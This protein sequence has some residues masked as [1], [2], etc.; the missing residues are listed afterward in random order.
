MNNAGKYK[1]ESEK[2]MLFDT[3]SQ[4]LVT[5]LADIAPDISVFLYILY[6]F[7]TA[8]LCVGNFAH[9]SEAAVLHLYSMY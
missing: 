6:V 8:S 1:E 3:H 9:L 2:Y 4:Y 5:S 7:H